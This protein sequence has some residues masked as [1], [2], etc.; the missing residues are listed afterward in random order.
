MDVPAPAASA[1]TAGIALAA[2]H[3]ASPAPVTGEGPPAAPRPGSPARPIRVLCLG[4]DL[5]ADDAVGIVAAR[6]LA[7]RLAA[8]GAPAP[9]GPAFDAA[10]TARAFDLPSAGRVEVLETALTGMYLLEAVVGASRLVVVDSVLSGTAEP[11]TVLD[12][13]EADLD[14]PRGGSPH[15]IGLLEA[16]DLARALGLAVPS[17]VAIV[18]IEVGDATTV[19]GAMTAPVAAAV[20]LVVERVMAH[21][22]GAAV[23]GAA[24][25]GRG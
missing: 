1:S 13:A 6:E 2:G 4:N 21:V 14:V 19:G 7:R 20:P 22:E 16:L 17:E 11:G 3:P 24:V 18:A 8:A 23:E 15:Y 9:A 25:E 5:I 10:A 12:L